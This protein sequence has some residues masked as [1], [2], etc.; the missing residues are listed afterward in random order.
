M[1]IKFFK[2]HYELNF[3]GQKYNLRI[4]TIQFAFWK[5]YEPI[6]DFRK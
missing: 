5:N 4:S 6:F 1:K 2:N 3:I